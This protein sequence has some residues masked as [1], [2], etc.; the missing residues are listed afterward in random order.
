M[1]VATGRVPNSDRLEVEA[2][3]VTTHADG[4]IVVDEFQRTTADGVYALGDI[5]SP[6]Q[7]KHVANHEA[8]I[9]QH[10]LLHP[11]DLIEAD[12]RYVPHAVFSSPQV[13][14]VGK[15]E[16]ELEASDT[17]YVAAT[18]AY[19]DVAY[20]WAMEDTTGFVKVLADPATGLLLGAHLI[21]PQAFQRHPADHHGDELRASRARDGPWTALDPP[22]H[23][24]G[25]GERPSPAA[26]RLT[27]P[28]AGGRTMQTCPRPIP[29]SP[30]MT[31]MSS[32]AVTGRAVSS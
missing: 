2:G 7:L 13:A 24:R 21:G 8:R 9:V 23:A 25:R 12:H 1:L 20:G 17:P 6:D 15:T 26:S 28:T 30:S 16:D 29:T 19:G 27:T 14:G 32:T 3:G 10:N 22:R 31:G 4:R 5:S 18:Q 11:R